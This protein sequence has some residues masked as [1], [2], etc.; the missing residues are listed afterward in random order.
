MT[1]KQVTR[2]RIC[3]RLLLIAQQ[4]QRTSIN[5]EPTCT[6][7]VKIKYTR[8][9]SHNTTSTASIVKIRLKLNS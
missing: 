6:G 3:Q 2:V 1:P 5:R 7:G 4:P 8:L 9:M